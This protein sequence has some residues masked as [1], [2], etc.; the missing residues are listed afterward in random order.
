M[1]EASVDNSLWEAL[2]PSC[3][4]SPTPP[5]PEAHHEY[6]ECLQSVGKFLAQAQDLSISPISTWHEVAQIKLWICEIDMH[7][8][9]NSQVH[10]LLQ[11][12]ETVKRSSEEED[13]RENSVVTSA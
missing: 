8:L 7:N 5:P 2:N 4:A 1:E 11:R 6:L 9:L 13:A 12:S 10:P 3:P